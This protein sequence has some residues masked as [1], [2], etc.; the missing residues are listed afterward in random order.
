M[1]VILLNYIDKICLYARNNVVRDI[2]TETYH[3]LDS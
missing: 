1:A 3:L 2:P